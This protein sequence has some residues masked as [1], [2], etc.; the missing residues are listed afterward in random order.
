MRNVQSRKKREFAL[1]LFGWNAIFIPL[2]VFIFVFFCIAVLVHCTTENRCALQMWFTLTSKWCKPSMRGALFR[3]YRILIVRIFCSSPRFNIRL[4]LFVFVIN[5]YWRFYWI[6]NISSIFN[7][8]KSLRCL[9]IE[10]NVIN[11]CKS[12]KWVFH[13]NGIPKNRK[14]KYPIKESYGR[15]ARQWSQSGRKKSR[16]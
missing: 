4:L 10:C 9:F 15:E 7:I 5:V 13:R 8:N 12:G 11:F 3:F 16:L 2:F 1:F 6:W 14:K